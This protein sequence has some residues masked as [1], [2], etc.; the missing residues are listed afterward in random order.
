VISSSPG[1]LPSSLLAVPSTF[2]SRAKGASRLYNL[3][4]S[5]ALNIEVKCIA[6]LITKILSTA[7][8]L[9]HSLGL[10]AQAT[11]FKSIMRS[12]SLW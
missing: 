12:T 6:D 10:G 5:F 11:V 7:M 2:I 4:D 8:L 1:F 9:C 3:I